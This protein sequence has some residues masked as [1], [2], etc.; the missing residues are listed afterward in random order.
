MTWVTK[1]NNAVGYRTSNGRFPKR[2]KRSLVLHSAA[3]ENG[4][5]MLREGG[6]RPRDARAFLSVC[7]CGLTVTSQKATNHDRNISYHTQKKERPSF[8]WLWVTSCTPI[9]FRGLPRDTNARPRRSPKTNTHPPQPPPRKG[10]SIISDFQAFSSSK[11]RR[12]LKKV[13]LQ[14][15]R[16]PAL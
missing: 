1:V 13:S 6:H 3:E 14:M 7:G 16:G 4:V 12:C 11:V 9:E 15:G 8:T 2:E 5:S 10:P